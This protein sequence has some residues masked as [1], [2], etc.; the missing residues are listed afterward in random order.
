MDLVREILLDLEKR[1][2]GAV[3]PTV[4]SYELSDRTQGAILHHLRIMKEANLISY[5]EGLPPSHQYVRMAWGGHE[6]LDAARSDSIWKKVTTDVA[7]HV[8]ST[9]FDVL[10]TY[11]K[12]EALRQL[13][14][15]RGAP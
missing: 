3:L 14:I 12:T 6:F 10:L 15:G 9:A 11:L 2:A 5:D 4:V 7:K 1:D 8:G 13:G